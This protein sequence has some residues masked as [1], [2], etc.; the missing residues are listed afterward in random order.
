MHKSRSWPSCVSR[1]PRSARRKG[2]FA[3]GLPAQQRSAA[4]AR[5]PEGGQGRQ[6]E[7]QARG[8][9]RGRSRGRL[10]LLRR[11][12]GVGYRR[13]A[14]GGVECEKLQILHVHSRS[15]NSQHLTRVAFS[16]GKEVRPPALAWW[17]NHKANKGLSS[18]LWIYRRRCLRA[19]TRPTRSGS[20]MSHVRISAPRATRA[21][22]RNAP[23]QL[24]FLA[25]QRGLT[26]PACFL[27][28]SRDTCAHAHR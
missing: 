16:E 28:L 9:R 3:R 6:A 17:L 27:F 15:T 23:L 13:G 4:R 22:P 5:A 10:T 20:R 24:F 11:P 25:A 26:T 21:H 1:H 2:C 8:A 7:R 19:T 12:R 18:L 14:Q